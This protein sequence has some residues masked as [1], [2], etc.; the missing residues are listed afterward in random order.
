MLNLEELG[1]VLKLGKFALAGI[2]EG[3][4]VQLKD[5]ATRIRFTAEID[6]LVHIFSVSANV[7]SS[8]GSL[9]APLLNFDFAVLSLG[10]A[11][12]TSMGP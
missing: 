8:L 2:L 4:V 7:E 12:S 5:L 9:T 6:Y 1:Q 10:N 11:A 3:T